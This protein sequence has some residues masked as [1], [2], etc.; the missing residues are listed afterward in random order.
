LVFYRSYAGRKA[1]TKDTAKN[2]Y[3]KLLETVVHAMP[4]AAEE[5]PLQEVFVCQL[6]Y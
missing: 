3:S 2:G 5:N 1:A 4:P 6:L